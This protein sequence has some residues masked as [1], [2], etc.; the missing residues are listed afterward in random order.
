LYFI[1][2][3]ENSLNLLYIKTVQVIYFKHDL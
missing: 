2:Y 3:Y 1:K